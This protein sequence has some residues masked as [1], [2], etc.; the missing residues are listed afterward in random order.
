M[1]H[2]II[3][4]PGLGDDKQWLVRLQEWALGFWRINRVKTTVLPMVWADPV[5]FCPRFEKLLTKI[6]ELHAEGKE[7]S[8]VG[9]SAGA[10]AVVSAFALRPDKI[11]G[12]VTICGKL[13]GGIPQLVKDLNPSF[14]ESLGMLAKSVK[15]LPSVRKKQIMNMYS[16][17]DLVVPADQAVMK[18]ARHYEIKGL[19]HNPSCAYILLFKSRTIVRFLKSRVGT[20]ATELSQ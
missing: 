15:K 3:Y 9:T 5:P 1:K 18:G 16:P 7:V 2:V 13:Q 10:S 19:G 17:L 6:D 20:D 14:G 4:V 8:L 12:V 11:Q